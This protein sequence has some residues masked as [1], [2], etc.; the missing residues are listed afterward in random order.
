MK[1]INSCAR[2]CECMWAPPRSLVSTDQNNST[3]SPTNQICA[4]YTAIPLLFN[5][6]SMQK[7]RRNPDQDANRAQHSRC[8]LYR[9]QW[10]ANTV[11]H[12]VCICPQSEIER[13]R[14]EN[15]W[16]T[17]YDER[18]VQIGCAANNM[19]RFLFVSAEFLRICSCLNCEQTQ[20]RDCA[21]FLTVRIL[22]RMRHSD[23]A[24]RMV[25]NWHFTECIWLTNR[26][27][28]VR[29]KL[30]IKFKSTMKY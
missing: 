6:R 29:W 19:R 28:F 4:K 21:L 13:E 16:C 26:I 23:N 9:V 7:S 2:R 22:F 5:I 20:K 17:T 14:D 8:T 10:M 30:E 27:S 1:P 3:C 12:R 25:W 15:R 18:N 24:R 11:Y